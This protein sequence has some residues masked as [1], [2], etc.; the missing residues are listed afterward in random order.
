M[1][2]IPHDEER[3][4]KVDILEMI[5]YDDAIKPNA[6]SLQTI[7][8]GVARHERETIVRWIQE[9]VDNSDCPLEYSN[10]QDSAVWFANRDQAVLF[11]DN[12]KG[13]PWYQ[14][15]LD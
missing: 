7:Q 13:D 8:N 10:E 2:Y 6:I 15:D 11:I 9:L 1:D 4:I 3:E 5:L 12:L 14:P